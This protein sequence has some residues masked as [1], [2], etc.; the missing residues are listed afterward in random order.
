[1]PQAR[2]AVESSGPLRVALNLARSIYERHAVGC[3]LHLVIDDGNLKN[4]HV[5]FCLR[6]AREHEHKDCERLARM[7]R[8]MTLKE[9]RKFYALLHRR[10]A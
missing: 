3:C 7:I 1:M 9:R 6:Q 2:S 5:A 8:G 10:S 4:E